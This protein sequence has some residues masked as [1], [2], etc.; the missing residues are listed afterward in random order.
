MHDEPEFGSQPFPRA[1]LIAAGS[2]IAVTLIGV[3]VARYTG[4]DPRVSPPAPAV[5]SRSLAFIDRPDGSLG[6]VDVDQ[7]TEVAAL[8]PGNEG[9]LRAT[10]RSL[11]RERKRQGIPADAPYRLVA[12][13]DGHVTL[14]DPSTG[15]LFDLGS[16]GPSN[17]AVFAR[18]LPPPNS[19][20]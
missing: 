8:P 14:E 1:P 20:R 9:F 3:A 10:L 17:L 13:A 15:R 7:H 16:F 11:Y 6:V 5:Q 4:F 18:L 2:L 12:H 19:E